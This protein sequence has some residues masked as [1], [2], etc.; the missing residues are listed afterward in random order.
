M[1][2]K[3]AERKARAHKIVAHLKT[4]YPEPKSELTYATPFQFVVAVVLSAQCT[5]KVVNRVTDAL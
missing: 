5:D 4:H 3:Q 1:D 2:G